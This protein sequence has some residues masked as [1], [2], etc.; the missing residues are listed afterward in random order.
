MAAEDRV[1]RRQEFVEAARRCV[2]RD[3]YRNLTVDNVCMEAGLSKGAFYSHF[4][5]K[6][7]L[8]VAV[9][10]DDASRVGALINTVTERND[11]QLERTRRYVQSLLREAE[12]PGGVQLR[13]GLWSETLSDP[14]ITEGLVADIRERR[15]QLRDWIASGIDSG[16]L[17]ET[18]A[19]ATAA[20]LVALADG[21]TLHRAIDP[22]AFQ[23]PNIRT[24]LATLLDGLA[25]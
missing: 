3:G 13:A 20:I 18:P 9:L 14:A 7:E 16:E 22:S 17:V 2:A 19:N 24:A 5:T 12:E 11:S 6:S 8:L 15:R 4:Q 21:L 1:A 23:W 25:A 10:E